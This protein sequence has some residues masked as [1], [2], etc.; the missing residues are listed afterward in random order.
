MRET[1]VDIISD[2]HGLLTEELK[3]E[4][5]GADHI[6]HAG[7][8]TSSADYRTLAAM[9]PLH[10]CLGNNDHVGQYPPEV[11]RILRF[12]IDGV[13][14]QVAHYQSDLEPQYADVCVFGHTHRPGI[15]RA[16]MGG[17]PAPRRR[18][19]RDRPREIAQP[20]MADGVPSPLG[21]TAVSSDAPGALMINPGSPTLPRTSLGP[22]M[23]RLWIRDGILEDPE[24]IQLPVS[25]IQRERFW[26]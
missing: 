18:F 12:K 22:T 15:S 4:L 10:C 19:S 11:K 7:D 23:A 16:T 25:D 1:R 14:F 8:M 24:I 6:I 3:Q 20:T 5:R 17:Q 21:Q 2:T 13:R 26:F 9:A